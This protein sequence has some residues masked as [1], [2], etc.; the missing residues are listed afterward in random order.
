MV[1][2]LNLVDQVPKSNHSRELLQPA[3]VQPMIL[4]ETEKQIV[5]LLAAMVLGR[6]QEALHV[7]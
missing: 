6:H 1:A 2:L 5:Q 4:H 3:R 7:C